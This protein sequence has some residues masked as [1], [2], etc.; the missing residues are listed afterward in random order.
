MIY[1][2][3]I[4]PYISQKLCATKSPFKIGYAFHL[5]PAELCLFFNE[6]KHRSGET[7]SLGSS[8]CS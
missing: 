4:A 8:G 2:S 5:S 1:S 7:G 3:S 6:K